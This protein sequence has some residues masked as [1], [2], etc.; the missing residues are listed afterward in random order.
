LL[1][2]GRAKRRRQQRKAEKRQS[3]SRRFRERVLAGFS[4]VVERRRMP[5]P[6]HPEAESPGDAIA[7][8]ERPDDPEGGAPVREPRRPKPHGPLAG[9]VEL[10]LPPDEED[11]DAIGASR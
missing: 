7:L 2:S 9:A 5:G 3:T 1:G 8:M 10:E 11:L 4:A 6:P